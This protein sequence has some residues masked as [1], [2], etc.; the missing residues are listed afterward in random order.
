MAAGCQQNAYPQR[1]EK[2]L[3][4]WLSVEKCLNG[5]QSVFFDIPPYASMSSAITPSLI[6]LPWVRKVPIYN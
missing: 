4:S 6:S 1:N 5:A 3:S 2:G